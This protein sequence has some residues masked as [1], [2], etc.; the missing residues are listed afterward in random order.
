M[1]WSE[2]Q[3]DWPK[4][5]TLLQSYWPCLTHTDLKTID[6]DRA[7]LALAIRTRYALSGQQIENAIC[8]FEKDVRF[9]GAVK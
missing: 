4:M 1:N 8:T 3:N 2:I 9:P 5:G 7:K 6:G